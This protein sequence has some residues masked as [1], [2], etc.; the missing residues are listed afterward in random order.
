MTY[1]CLNRWA[2][3]PILNADLQ[4]A[5][6]FVDY[7][8]LAQMFFARRTERPD[9]AAYRYKKDGKWLSVSFKEAV[10]QCERI[11]AGL[12]N[13]GIQAG[14]NVAIISNN[15]LEWA[16][17]DYATI[18]VGAVL[19]PVYPSLLEE[20]VQFLLNHSEAKMVF[21][22]NNIQIK[23]VDAIQKT[24]SNCKQYICIENCADREGWQSLSHLS[25]QGAKKLITEPDCVQSAI[26]G[27]NRDQIATIIYTS[28]TTGEP[29]GALLSHHN[30]LSNIENAANIFT[31]Y[32]TDLLLSF[33]PLSHVLERMAGH[34][35]ATFHNIEV[36]HAESIEAVPQNILEV[37]P[38][39]MISV[40]RLYEKMYT[41]I[42][43]AV[44]TGSALKQKIFYWAIKVGEVTIQAKMQHQTPGAGHKLKQV[45]ADKLVFSKLKE[46]MGGRIRFFVS[47]GA[48][49]SA[50][51]AA[52]FGAA[53]LYIFE[54][55]G[56]TETSPAITMNSLEHFRYGTVG[57]V[58]PN[59]E[60]KIAEDGEI[61][62]RGG[63]VMKGYYKNPD[64][65]AEVLDAEGWFY[66]GDIG[67]LDEDDYLVITDRKKNIIVTSGGK[68]I[69]PQPIENALVSSKYIE[70]SVMIGDKRK[71][72]TAVIVL[73]DEAVLRWTTENGMNSL[74]P[75]DF[76]GN[77]ALRTL[78]LG[79]IDRLTEHTVSYEKINDFY[80]APK[81]FS[82][83]S[84]DLTPSL[85]VK[86]NVV[87]IKYATEIDTLYKEQ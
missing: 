8:N 65:T 62:T 79:E 9:K 83:E 85:K 43:E 82:I 71:Y 74:L 46:K 13:L 5:E 49:L 24:L 32:D 40:P 26:K 2:K 66:T 75:K 20:Q 29:K 63:H 41:K 73:S 61:L 72:C 22:E 3:K 77:E 11:A 78:I 28:G 37:R 1:C 57:K 19:V 31:F 67:Y 59:E 14:D 35:Q 68:N 48:P 86:R 27:I 25:D 39:L 23:K 17:I 33:L 84:D 7:Q 12:L 45:L 6:V 30:F 15:R 56:L 54:G 10:D 36:V 44:E 55:Y 52:F 80:L 51:I 58:L 38:T 60:V 70:Q 50:E 47:G 87:T 64:D 69:A 18:S 76:N 16:L 21:A 34:Y 53:G 4:D 81:P 42:L